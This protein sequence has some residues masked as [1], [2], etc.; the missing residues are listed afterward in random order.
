MP[1]QINLCTPILLTQKRY[2]SA[3]TMAQALAVFVAIGGG[4]AAYGVWSLKTS[5]EG[6]QQTLVAHNRELEGLRSAIQTARMGSGPV[7]TRLAQELQSRR[8][9]LVNRE[10]VLQELHKGLFKTGA[11][12]SARLQLIA[13]SVPPQV[14][15][16]EIKADDQQLDVSGFT[17][18]P[19]ALNEW[20]QRLA[21]SPLLRGQRL[22]SIKV[23]RANG[24][25]M[26]GATGPSA[27]MLSPIDAAM[28]GPQRPLWSFTL[29]S[30]VG[31]SAGGTV[32]GAP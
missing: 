24:A 4:L 15:V 23:Q 21:S 13:Q 11:G 25:G 30:A 12:Q 2:F 14:W 26:P 3:R 9:D 22:A 1:Q 7:D 31:P 27:A 18:E 10:K 32:K 16:T 17:L 6:F 28:S 5:S 29:V 19:S 20:V 8:A